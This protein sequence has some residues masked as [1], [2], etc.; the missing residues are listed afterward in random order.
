M[1]GREAAHTSMP[2]ENGNEENQLHGASGDASDLLD[3]E[4]NEDK[5]D[6]NGKLANDDP[7]DLSESVLHAAGNP[8]N[9][10]NN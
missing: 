9:A 2:N 7:N 4:K 10:N 5:F 8:I 3:G 1:Q 6:E